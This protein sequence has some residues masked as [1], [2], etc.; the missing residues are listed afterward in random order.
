MSSDTTSNSATLF[1]TLG[2]TLGTLLALPSLIGYAMSTGVLGRDRAFTLASERLAVYGGQLGIYTRQAFY[3][4]TTAGVGRDVCFGF[5]SVFSK[6]AARIGHR[7]Y[8][9]RFCSIGWADIHDDV[10][11]ADGVQVLSGRHQHGASSRR[12]MA[13][14]ENVQAYKKVT[15]GR[16]AWIGAGAVVMA[17]VGEGAVVAA[18]AVVV[19]PVPAYDRVGGVPAATLGADSTIHLDQHAKAA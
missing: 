10:M 15:I 17:D 16:G 4:Y 5:M 12:G 7:V 6:P 3:R 14:R 2:R 8:I 13:L 11:L 19:K 18:G 9:G 1:K